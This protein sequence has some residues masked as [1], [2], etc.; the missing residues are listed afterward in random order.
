MKMKIYSESASYT[1]SKYILFDTFNK[2]FDLGQNPSTTF[3]EKIP[4]SGKL[5]FFLNG[6]IYSCLTPNPL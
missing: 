4:I 5:I 1:G 6:F 2:Y 3:P